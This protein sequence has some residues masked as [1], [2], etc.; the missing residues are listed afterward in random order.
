MMTKLKKTKPLILAIL[1]FAAGFFTCLAFYS[2]F[3]NRELSDS[4]SIESQADIYKFVVRERG[5]ADFDGDGSPELVLAFSKDDYF[6]K[7]I[8]FGGYIAAFKENGE[9]IARTAEDFTPI[10][11]TL[12]SH[13]K[14]Y[15]LDTN[16][17]KEYLRLEVVAGTHQFK[18]LFLGTDGN[19]LLPICKKGEPEEIDDCIFY[20]TRGELTVDDI[21]KNGL[22]DIVE[23]V[24]EYPPKGGRGKAVAW[25]I[26][27]FNGKYFEPKLNEA[28]EK[29]FVLLSKQDSSLMRGSELSEESIENLQMIKN[30]WE[31]E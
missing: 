10:Y 23:I 12:P 14:S 11:S 7:E 20:N 24:D 2:K 25:G 27:S 5:W 15:Q 19:K 26:Y 9:E 22:T 16:S 4:P 29:I 1:L 18:T 3:S 13:M 8:D 6:N 17:K 21:D 28:Y 31:H 30:F